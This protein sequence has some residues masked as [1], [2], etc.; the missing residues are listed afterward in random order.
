MERESGRQKVPRGF[1]TVDIGLTSLHDLD[2]CA[3]RMPLGCK[4]GCIKGPVC[5]IQKHLAVKLQISKHNFLFSGDYTFM[6]RSF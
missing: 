2:C 4:H 3:S 1:G 6:K 5:E